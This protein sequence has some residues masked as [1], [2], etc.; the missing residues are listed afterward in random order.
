MFINI[1]YYEW[2]T[3]ISLFELG[4]LNMNVSNTVLIS[5]SSQSR[6]IYRIGLSSHVQYK[7]FIKDSF[8]TMLVILMNVNMFYG[9]KCFQQI[10]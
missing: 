1:L 6:S 9:D 8:H 7:S 4:K 5:F 2:K 3:D 10:N